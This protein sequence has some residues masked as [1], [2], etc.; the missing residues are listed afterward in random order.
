MDIRA[1]HNSPSVES[2]T[3]FLPEMSF[4]T[5]KQTKVYK[6]DTKFYCGWTFLYGAIFLCAGWDPSE[7]VLFGW[8]YIP[9]CGHGWVEPSL[10]SLVNVKIK[11]PS[12]SWVDAFK[13]GPKTVEELNK[14]LPEEKKIKCDVSVMTLP[15]GVKIY[16]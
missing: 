9:N 7:S 15:N 3:G 4:T 16:I 10:E 5:W 12:L 6:P 14:L 1:I 8:G 2:F 11:E 13:D